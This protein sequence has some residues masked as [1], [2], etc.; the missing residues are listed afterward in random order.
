MTSVDNSKQQNEYEYLVEKLF[1]EHFLGDKDVPSIPEMKAY[2]FKNAETNKN[3]RLLKSLLF[4]QWH[5][6]LIKSFD[7]RRKL[8]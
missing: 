2:V 5:W 4:T 7:D 1:E 3:A 8:I 6:R